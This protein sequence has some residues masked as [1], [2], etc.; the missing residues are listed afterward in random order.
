[1]ANITAN[2]I[3]EL[4]T[5][6][7]NI[8]GT[9]S[10][11][12]G[13]GQTLASSQVST[14]DIVDADHL[15]NMYADLIRMR[16]HQVGTFS[17]LTNVD[18]NL[19]VIAEETS[20][21]VNNSGQQSADPEGTY[22]GILD[23]ERLMSSIE[24]DKFLIDTTQAKIEDVLSS[25]RSVS[26]NDSIY[27]EFSVTFQ[28]ENHR[29]HFFNS[30]GQIRFSATNTGTSLSDKGTSWKTLCEQVGIVKFNY[31]ST[32]S[33]S[34]NGQGSNIGNYGLTTT[35]QTIYTYTTGTGTYAGNFYKI[36]AYSNGTNKIYFKVEFNDFASGD[37]DVNV[38]GTLT[39]K[40]Q[41]YISTDR[42]I[43]AAPEY[44]TEKGL[45]EFAESQ[46][47]RLSADKTVVNEGGSVAVTLRT[48][49]VS[50]NTTVPYTITGV[51]TD[52][53]GISLTGNFT[54][55]STGE[56]NITIP[57]STDSVSDENETLLLSL[58]NNE[59]SISISI[60]DLVQT[61]TVTTNK[62]EVVEG[63]SIEITL[64]TT[65]VQNGTIIYWKDFTGTSI[66]P[67]A[68]DYSDNANSGSFSIN[69][70]IYVLSRTLVLDTVTENESLNIEFF[71]DSAY[72]NKVASTG[73]IP[74][75]DIEWTV[76]ADQS[77]VDEDTD[78]GFSV[79]VS[80]PAARN[81]WYTWGTVEGSGST[82]S[83]GATGLTVKSPLVTTDS[84]IPMIIYNDANRTVEVDR[85]NVTVNNVEVQWTL[86]PDTITVYEFESALFTV[87]GS[88]NTT[89]Y[90]KTSDSETLTDFTNGTE[91]TTQADGTKEFTISSTDG[92]TTRYVHI[93]ADASST[94]SYDVSTLN[95]T[96]VP[97]TINIAE[98]SVIAGSFINATVT[99][100]KGQKY[101]LR[102]TTSTS[103]TASG[104]LLTTEL[105]MPNDRT[106]T[107]SI[108]VPN[109]TGTI[110]IHV[111]VSASESRVE[112]TTVI[113]DTLTVTSAV[114]WGASVSPSS[115]TQNNS[116]TFTITGQSGSQYYYK[117][118]TS[119]SASALYSGSGTMPSNNTTSFSKGMTTVGTYYLY[120][121][122]DAGYSTLVASSSGVTVTVQA[123]TPSI[124]SIG[125][126][127]ST[128]YTNASPSSSTLSWTTSNASSVQYALTSSATT[129]TTGWINGNI[130]GSASYSASS[131]GTI[132]GHVKAISSTGQTATTYRTLAITTQVITY[133][134]SVSKSSP[135]TVYGGTSTTFS[136]S[137]SPAASRS[138]TYSW[139]TKSGSGTT[140][141][142]GTASFSVSAPTVTSSGNV[143]LYIYE[144]NVQKASVNV[145][146]TYVAPVSWSI[147]GS[148]SVNSGESSTYTVTGPNST[149]AYWRLGSTLSSSTYKGSL[150]TNS[151]GSASISV[152]F[153]SVT[154]TQT[155][156]IWI[157]N[158]STTTSSSLTS[159]SVTI[160]Y[161]ASWSVY[162]PGVNSPYSAYE[163]T[164]GTFYISGPPSTT[165]YYR[166]GT[167]LSSSTYK[168][169]TATNTAGSATATVA[170]F[171]LVSSNSTN[172]IYL[173]TSTTTTSSSLASSSFTI[174]N[175]PW[176]VSGTSSGQTGSSASWTVSGPSGQYFSVRLRTSATA[177]SVLN[178]TGTTGTANINGVGSDTVSG[179]LPSTTGSYTLYVYDILG[180]TVATYS[181]TVNASWSI[182]G[183]NSVPSGGSATYTITGTASTTVKVYRDSVYAAAVTLNSSGS[184]T[185]TLTFPTVTQTTD[186]LITVTN[187]NSITTIYAVKTV[188]VTYTAPSYDIRIVSSSSV[189]DLTFLSVTA[190]A[191]DAVVY[192]GASD[193]TTIKIPTYFAGDAGQDGTAGSTGV[194]WGIAYRALTSSI[195]SISGLASSGVSHAAVV[196]RDANLVSG[197]G[198]FGFGTGIIS[199]ASDTFGSGTITGLSTSKTYLIVI[200]I[201][202][203]DCSTTSAT[204][205]SGFT[206]NIIRSKTNSTTT[207][208]D[209]ENSNRTVIIGSK[210]V[211]GV[212]SVY[213][214]G[215][216]IP[217]AKTAAYSTSVSYAVG[218]FYIEQKS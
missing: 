218:G 170:A 209:D 18:E 119:T 190:S 114:S 81:F 49:G 182:S 96:N 83:A 117:I 100:P 196:V 171:P 168:G 75:I 28:D 87:T 200:T 137:V 179:T 45:N 110:Y 138:F 111:S 188:S 187:F 144:N 131:A 40:I 59:D 122:T 143:T 141:T 86:S 85:V 211:S 42:V 7:A 88:P 112:G 202:I 149:T 108:Q 165:V 56:G 194:C 74:I 166:I 162:G 22:N 62:T 93:F 36:S 32:A 183:S 181:V 206:R 97:W 216:T 90:S 1:M 77:T 52:D 157:V 2:R 197:G 213:F 103:K 210:K 158:S 176:T 94:T 189:N 134:W 47:F 6:I 205:G 161:V 163:A 12:S 133:S 37:F 121:Y 95:I 19:N 195:T 63:E 212:S 146:I 4:Q 201:A 191:N 58:D 72:T 53:I 13:Y 154:S 208:F 148:S 107:T 102:W 124:T 84:T 155:T 80:P 184:K 113:Y 127:N 44:T 57:I 217:N 39:S 120:V 70:N 204:L 38:D 24:A 173:T 104:T 43:I 123:I 5:R 26:W 207:T 68:D 73:L 167:T 172:Y 21:F 132:Y 23:Y 30:G 35:Y 10:G 99:G 65:N 69:N 3:N 180:T 76:A 129:P 106:Q 34:G 145:Y 64:T 50:Q 27:H 186:S 8:L 126:N 25:A 17:N 177:T 11:Q 61:Y 115:V 147:S 89:F 199:T 150:T 71:T 16:I 153:P 118:A 142:S 105:T 60:S 136:V 175:V 198:Q 174:L 33:L 169:Y 185:V 46:S 116:A 9:G 92:E 54:I 151:S 67:E 159:K 125:W 48:T 128:I 41:H 130:N 66:S 203:D 156:Y 20:Y 31:N 160:N 82:S 178:D 101:Y 140:N 214:S 78:S 109:T 51:T 29:R 192:A 152:S 164:S 135:S 55:G 15:N 139:S 215:V 14:T 98:S 91:Q 193:E 79:L